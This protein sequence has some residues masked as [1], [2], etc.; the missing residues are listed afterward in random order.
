[1]GDCR[2]LSLDLFQTRT[3]SIP[4]SRTIH[5]LELP[6]YQT[7]ALYICHIRSTMTLGPR[8]DK[9]R[10]SS[11]T[12]NMNK[13]KTPVISHKLAVTYSTITC[14]IFRRIPLHDIKL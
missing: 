4:D 3:T 7:H 11:T 8:T 10:G 6:Q 9:E 13:S 12:S 5:I 1:G 2:D 14:P